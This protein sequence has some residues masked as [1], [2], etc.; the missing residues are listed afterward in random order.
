MKR[1]T[2][3]QAN[4]Y[5]QRKR[6]KTRRNHGRRGEQQQQGELTRK[7]FRLW[8]V[9]RRWKRA[10]RE[11]K[12]MRSISCNGRRAMAGVR[13][14]LK[15]RTHPPHGLVRVQ[16]GVR[17]DM[18]RGPVQG[19]PAGAQLEES[20]HRKHRGVQHGVGRG[21][22]AVA[23]VAVRLSTLGVHHGVPKIL[24]ATF[25]HEIMQRHPPSW[26]KNCRSTESGG[27][28]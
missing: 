8:E 10:S 20:N 28:T 15:Q 19:R 5:L 18:L 9:G 7:V 27:E 13:L 23:M 17:P 25:S 1:R 11:S 2:H 21:L 14:E 26:E 12:T 16:A 22:A 3:G 6:G 4:A 24:V